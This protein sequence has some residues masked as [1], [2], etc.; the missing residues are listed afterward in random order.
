MQLRPFGTHGARKTT[1]S[2]L[3]RHLPV[4]RAKLERENETNSRHLV[5]AVV[6]TGSSTQP[7]S[8]G[9]VDWQRTH[10]HGRRHAAVAECQLSPRLAG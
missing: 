6:P 9:V 10:S 5:G 7:A 3:L 8:V 1:G 4:L 2:L